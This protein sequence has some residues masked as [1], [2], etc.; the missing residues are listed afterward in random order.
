MERVKRNLYSLCGK[1]ALKVK[2]KEIEED[3]IEFDEEEW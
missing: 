1:K 2:P 3:K